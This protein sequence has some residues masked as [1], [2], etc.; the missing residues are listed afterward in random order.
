VKTQAKAESVSSMVGL[1]MRISA[2]PA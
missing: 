2:E 1:F